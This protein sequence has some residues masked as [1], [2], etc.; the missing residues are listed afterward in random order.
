MPFE[1]G[2]WVEALLADR[3][4][5]G[6]QIVEGS[7]YQVAE[8]DDGFNVDATCTGCGPDCSHQ[9]IALEGQPMPPHLMWCASSF[10][11]VYRPRSS[12]VV[13]LMES[14]LAPKMPET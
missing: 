4:W 6:C 14:A 3:C 9:G 5:P 12:W 10:R 13:I 7:L 1:R 2:D 11:P 8:V